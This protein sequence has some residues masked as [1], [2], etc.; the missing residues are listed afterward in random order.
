MASATDDQYT[1]IRIQCSSPYLAFRAN[2]P[3]EHE[4][5]S[6]LRTTR[7]VPATTLTSPSSVDAKSTLK[8][9]MSELQRWHLQFSGRDIVEVFEDGNLVAS[10]HGQGRDGALL[11]A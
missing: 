9:A 11:D 1:S 8:R 6:G 3:Q 2:R 4:A 5:S 7:D 10:G